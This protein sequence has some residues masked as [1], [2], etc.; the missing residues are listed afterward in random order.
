MATYE[1]TGPAVFPKDEAGKVRAYYTGAVL[2]AG[3]S[4]EELDRLAGRGLITKVA[5]PPAVVTEPVDQAD[6]ATEAGAT[7]SP[8]TTEPATVERPPQVAPKPA[9]VDYAVAR[10]MDRTKAEAMTKPQ[11]VDAFAPE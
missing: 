7:G 4:T 6:S 1:V 10:G 3:I 5:T 2:P 8:A 11:L 9:W